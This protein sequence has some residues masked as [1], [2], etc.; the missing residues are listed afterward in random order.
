MMPAL[1]L[2]LLC[3]TGVAASVS[4]QIQLGDLE[5]FIPPKP[6]W[7]LKHWNVSIHNDD[8]TPL[9]VVN[10]GEPPTAATVS[11]ALEQYEEDD[12]WTKRFTQSMLHLYSVSLANCLVLYLQS[13][14]DESKDFKSDDYNVSA[15]YTGT[16][17][18]PAGPYFVH[19]YTG[20]V[21]QAYRLYVDTS[22]AFIQ[23][24]LLLIISTSLM[25]A[26]NIPRPPRN[27][28]SSP[29]SN[30]VRSRSYY[31]RPITSLLY[32]Y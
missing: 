18:G 27:S 17:S 23:V 15:V 1:Y 24:C 29:S 32:A 11:D 19:R 7:K 12:V 26:V 16:E 8:F 9:T 22:Q 6:A 3:V 2:A 5:Y 31:R 21:Y 30:S 10:L 14:A 13:D 4:R 28:S 20:D 25:A